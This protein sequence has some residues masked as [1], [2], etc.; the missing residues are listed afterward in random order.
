MIAGIASFVPYLGF[1]VGIIAA[2]IAGLLEFGTDWI[3][4]AMIVGAFMIGQVM[5]GYVLQP[6]LLGDKI[7]LS[8]LWVILWYWQGHL[9]LVLQE[10]SLLC[11]WRRYLMC[12]FITPTK[13]IKQRIL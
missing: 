10:C 7:G 9:C 13:A 1:G 2:M 5:E 12:Y 8:P 4:L 11:L 6:L 3:K